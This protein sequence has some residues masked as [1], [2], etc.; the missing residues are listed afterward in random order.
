MT[1]NSTPAS[2]T[3]R[4][5]VLKTDPEVFDAVAAGLKTH[6]IRFNDRDFCVG[7]VLVLYRTKH[8]GAEMRNGCPLIYEGAPIRKVVSHVLSGYGLSEGWVILSFATPAAGVPAPVEAGFGLSAGQLE[9]L[10]TNSLKPEEIAGPADAQQKR[11]RELTHWFARLAGGNANPKWTR[12]HAMELAY[13][14]ATEG[15]D[16]GLDLSAIEDAAFTKGVNTTP[17]ERAMLQ[18]IAPN[19]FPATVPAVAGEG[20][21]D[22]EIVRIAETLGKEEPGVS[23]YDS[24]GSNYYRADE[25][26]DFTIPQVPKN[27]IPFARAIIATATPSTG[28]LL[29][30]SE[31]VH[32][33][34]MSGKIAK[35]SMLQCAHTHGE[36]AVADYRRLTENTGAAEPMVSCNK[37][38]QGNDYCDRCAEGHYERCRYVVASGAAEPVP[39]AVDTLC[40]RCNGSG[41]Q[42][43]LVGGGPDA[44]DEVGPCSECGGTGGLAT[45]PPGGAT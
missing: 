40:P 35:I 7:D 15:K 37:V 29:E 13:Y 5:H 39:G 2:V 18:R 6:E 9:T 14:I 3:R 10:R 33:A 19:K 12:A 28:A 17:A 4:E 43:Y 26:G 11:V 38:P 44:Y 27:C 42:E 41:D 36:Q 31:G 20:L 32:L 45:T 8:T 24:W 30:D 34:M 1:N 25:N 22:A 16:R 23:N 21:T